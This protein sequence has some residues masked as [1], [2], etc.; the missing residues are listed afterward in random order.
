MLADN[1][2]LVVGGRVPKMDDDTMEILSEE[3]L[4][5]YLSYI[6][7]LKSLYTMYLHPNYNAGKK[8]RLLSPISLTR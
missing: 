7:Q 2:S 1:C 8:V 6:D 4:L 5:V 3:A